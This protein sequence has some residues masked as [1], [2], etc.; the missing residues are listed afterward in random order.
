[1]LV[2][3]LSMLLQMTLGKSFA[4]AVASLKNDRTQSAFADAVPLAPARIVRGEDAAV[5]CCV[6]NK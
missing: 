3:I 2:K 1:M 4:P 5:H 6:D